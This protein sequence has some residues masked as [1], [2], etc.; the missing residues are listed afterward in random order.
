MCLVGPPIGEAGV[1]E[2]LGEVKVGIVKRCPKFG[3]M[4]CGVF[5]CVR[6][7]GKGHGVAPWAA[8]FPS[9]LSE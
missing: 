7:L 1:A 9:A 5:A 2:V 4:K 8:G 3:A 6:R